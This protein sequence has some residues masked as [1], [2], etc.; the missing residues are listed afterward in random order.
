MSPIAASFMD[1]CMALPSRFSPTL[2]ISA[3]T[4][5]LL[6][7]SLLWVVVVLF[8]SIE[9]LRSGCSGWAGR[10]REAREAGRAMHDGANVMS[11]P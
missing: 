4:P 7:C 11:S 8:T 2:L 1:Q 10:T 6:T 9:V 3:V 5:A